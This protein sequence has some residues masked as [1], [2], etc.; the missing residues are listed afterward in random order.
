MGQPIMVTYVSANYFTVTDMGAGI[1][2]DK[3]WGSLELYTYS[4][5]YGVKVGSV[6]SHLNGSVQ[7]F[8]GLPELN[9]PVWT[10]EHYEPDPVRF[11]LPVPHRILFSDLDQIIPNMAGYKSG[12][13]EIMSDSNETW[14]ICGLNGTSLTSYYKYGEWIVTTTRGAC[15]NASKSFDIVT[16]AGVPDFNPLNNVGKK[17]CHMTGILTVV[18]PAPRINLWTITPRSLDDFPVAGNVVDMTTP[19][20]P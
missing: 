10:V 13:V 15:S 6:V 17:I 5:P 7:N 4:Q 14:V 9:F 16:T 3:Q 2:D 11:P 12:L 20:P 18:V 1:G 8:L 19:C